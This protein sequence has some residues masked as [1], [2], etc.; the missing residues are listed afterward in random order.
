[1]PSRR[2]SGLFPFF[3]SQAEASDVSLPD[4]LGDEK[5]GL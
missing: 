3:F 4:P 2:K 5:P 1:M